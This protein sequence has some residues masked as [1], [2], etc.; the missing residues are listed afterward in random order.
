LLHN[1]GT[2]GSY[3]TKI[4]YLSILGT[5]PE[6]FFL[7]QFVIELVVDWVFWLTFDKRRSMLIHDMSSAGIL[8]HE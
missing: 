5:V 3:F 4:D 2:Y 6:V 8:L 1:I 7:F